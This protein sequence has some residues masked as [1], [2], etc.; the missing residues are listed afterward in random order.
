MTSLS[1]SRRLL[2][3]VDAITLAVSLVAVLQFVFDRASARTALGIVF[4]VPGLVWALR[5]IVRGIVVAISGREVSADRFG[6]ESS[7]PPERLGRPTWE[8]ARYKPDARRLVV[9]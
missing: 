4:M 3:L 6:G 2:R 7:T 5:R 1:R 8:R 9:D